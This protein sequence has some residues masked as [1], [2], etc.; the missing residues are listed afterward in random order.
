VTISFSSTT[1]G[2]CQLTAQPNELISWANFTLALRPPPPFR[3]PHSALRISPSPS[4]ALPET[5]ASFPAEGVARYDARCSTSAS[6]S[7]SN[8]IHP[9]PATGRQVRFTFAGRELTGIEGE[10]VSSALIAN[11]IYVFG[12]TPATATPGIFCANGQCSQ[13]TVLVE[14]GR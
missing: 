14:G 11:G 2:A 4:F 12:I 5:C 3:T 1:G 10:A 6:C 13:C 7:I 9:F 8:D